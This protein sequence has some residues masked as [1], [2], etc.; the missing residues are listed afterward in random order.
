MQK[1]GYTRAAAKV[2][3]LLGIRDFSLLMKNLH[4]RVGQLIYHRTY[5]AAELVEQMQQLGLRRGSVVCIHAS[6]KEF[7]NYRGTPQEL[8]L[9]LMQAVGEEGT[10]MM[11]AYPQM[12]GLKADE[13][14]FDKRTARTA[15]GLLAETFRQMPG[16][17][18]SYN[19][20]HSVCAWG[21]KAHWLVK[22]HH[23][24]VNCWDE[25][26]PYY[27]LTELNGL[28]FALGLPRYF[29]G[30]FDH[31]VEALLYKEHPYWAQ[32]FPVEQT[33]HYLDEQEQVQTYTAKVSQ[34]D[35][36]SRESRLQRYFDQGMMRRAQLSNL[37]VVVYESGK[38]LAKM[39]ELGRRGIT[40]YYVPSPKEYSF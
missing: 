9:A 11:P 37:S 4:K 19:V 17:E 33:Y 34:L 3:K 35:R 38:C 7:Y 31:C 16:V 28:V 30:T 2:K 6:M 20:Q 23:L 1:S 12:E 29:I 40:M 39:L 13:Y 10:L 14:I 26:S 32:F 24:G 15:A 27:R 36:R 21:A 8:I 25:C 22:D 5:T 18:R